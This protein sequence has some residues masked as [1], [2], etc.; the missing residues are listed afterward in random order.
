MIFVTVGTHEQQFNRLVS[1][2]DLYQQNNPDEEVIVQYGYSTYE[3]K[4]A[5]AIDFLPYDEMD[6]KFENAD[7][8]ITHGGPASFLA[9]MKKNKKVVV[10]PRMLK[11]KEH[12]NNHQVEFLK[13]IEKQ[14]PQIVPVYEIED[15]TDAINE[16]KNSKLNSGENISHNK[17]FNEDFSDILD[18]LLG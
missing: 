8:I 5:T 1:A 17:K 12:V 6:N 7:V 16:V 10:V 4:K 3:C 13:R 9:A 2:V 11:Y 15:L 14:F 18:R